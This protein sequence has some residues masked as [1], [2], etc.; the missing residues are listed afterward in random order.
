MAAGDFTLDD[1]TELTANLAS[2]VLSIR[3]GDK[4]V[5]FT[6]AAEMRRTREQMRRELGVATPRRS[7]AHR[8]TFTRGDR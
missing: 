1:L 6:D 3:H 4:T 8:A 7:Q 5:T 2:G